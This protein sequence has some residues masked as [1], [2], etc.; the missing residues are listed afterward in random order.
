M[1]GPRDL[2]IDPVPAEV[3][4]PLRQKVLRV[5][6]PPEASVYQHDDAPTTLH[7]AASLPGHGVVGIATLRPEDRMAG[8]EPFHKPG[9]RFRGVAVDEAWRGQ[10]IGKALVARVL[11]EARARGAKELW[12]NARIRSVPFFLS[13][14]FHVMSGEFDMY[15]IGPHVVITMAL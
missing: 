11:Q 10:G 2:A 9:I 13:R 4:R 5:G 6:Q 14:H 1:L 15:P 12:A 7:F 8:Q 3:V